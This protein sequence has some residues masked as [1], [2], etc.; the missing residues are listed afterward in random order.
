MTRRPRVLAT[1]FLLV[2]FAGSG[3]TLSAQDGKVLTLD[4]YSL[5]RSITSTAMSPDGRWMTYAYS[6]N[7]GDDTLYVELL[8]GETI[9]EI[10]GGSRPGFSDDSRWMALM[11]TPAEDT[12]GR[13]GR[14]S[15]D[16]QQRPRRPAAGGGERKLQLLDLEAGTSIFVENVSG[17]TFSPDS[18]LLVMKMRQTAEGVEHEGTD[19][20][21][22][23][24]D[25]GRVQNIGNVNEYAFNEEG[26]LLA[27]TVD[28]AGGVGNGV[29]LMDLEDTIL[30]TLDSSEDTYAGLT[31]NEEGTALAVLRGSVPES[32]QQ[33]AN[34]IRVWTDVGGRREAALH[35]DPAA[36]PGFPEG[37]VLSE[38][39]GVRFT[40]NSAMLILGIKEQA[41]AVEESDE[42]RADV[43]VWHYKDERV[44]S[45]QMRQASRDR[46]QTWTSVLH[47]EG[48]RFLRLADETMESVSLTDDGRWGIGRDDNPYAGMITWG[49]GKADYYRVDTTTGERTLMVENLGRAMGTSP[50]SEWFLY[51]KDETVFARN[52]ASGAETNLSALAGVD[53]VNRLDDH[54]YE[55]PA[56]GVAGWS[57]DGRSVL[58]NHRFDIWSLP[59]AGGEAVNLTAGVGERDQ[60][61]FRIVR[62]DREQDTIDTREPILV[63]AY[64]EWTKKSGYFEVETGSEPEPLIFV[65]K[66]VG[67]LSKADEADRVMFT[68]QTFVEYPDYWV[69]DLS[70]SEPR[71]ITDANP[72]QAEY[73]WGRRILID[74]ENSRG[75]RLQATLALPAGYREGQRYPML[76]YHYELMSQNHHSYSMP[77]YD[78]RP[79]MST[80]AS[81]GYLVLQPD[82]R[83]ETG[84]PGSSAMD[85]V[86]AAVRKVIELG[87]ADPDHIG[88]QGHSWGGYQSSFMVTQTDLFACVVTGAP[89]TNLVS[90][91]N[92]LY[93]SSGTVQQ[94]I[95][96]VGQV[97]MGTTPFEDFEL[98]IS[99]SPI[100][101]TGNI[102]TP[103]MILHGTED[104]SVDWMQGLE[105]Y[106][107]ARRQGKEVILLSY[108]GEG[109]HLG[110]KENQIDFQIRMRQFFDHYL[111]DASAPT[112]MT[113]GVPF[114][115]KETADPRDGMPGDDSGRRRRR[116]PPGMN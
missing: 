69:S 58:L 34:E 109:H 56:Y 33:R 1:L 39:A 6:P 74:Y 80:Y 4:D 105:Y 86:G 14:L 115:D 116:I 26:T 98:F 41:E 103:F 45:V 90:F 65:D 88:L 8:D 66:S 25:T 30:R 93:K 52:I 83:Y 96:E 100:H 27:W 75:Q 76:V 61:R 43:D 31:W 49:G 79:H 21:L 91:Y 97:R 73:A 99:Q 110:R 50:D 106:N 40:D 7:E 82:I 59:L 48:L 24:L 114:L 54:P 15:D 78:D 28:A 18:R 42:E 77:R 29:Y 5:W 53:F 94:G 104:G 68:M 81:G 20:V 112:W 107:M 95:T 71:R 55:L 72:Q 62:L 3:A 2:L 9:H 85:C 47:L 19:L 51:L 13:R 16:L 44:Q 60:I 84:R 70:F 64:G 10:P 38:L 89:P 46:R 12:G 101:N 23:E 67:R 11:V 17:F 57:E 102:T 35:F 22:R 92:T 36:D 32:M 111:M 63:S 108:P 37:M 113:E 87:Y